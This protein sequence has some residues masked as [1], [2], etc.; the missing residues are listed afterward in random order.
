MRIYKIISIVIF[1]MGLSLTA[2]FIVVTSPAKVQSCAN[3]IE[4][5]SQL[6]APQDQSLNYHVWRVFPEDKRGFTIVVASVD[7]RHFNRN[8]MRALA[9]ELNAKFG[10]KSKLK[11][12]LLDDDNIARLF[13]TG[14]AEYSTYVTVERGR[15]YL[16]RTV[17]REYIQ[18][19]K[20]RRKALETVKLNC[21]AHRQSDR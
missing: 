12:G 20:Q 1:I 18:F 19:S 13:A 7:P 9:T 15:Y 11:V 16:D 14:R 4:A 3:A 10:D 2:L 21:V 17:C 5:S 8:D 6:T